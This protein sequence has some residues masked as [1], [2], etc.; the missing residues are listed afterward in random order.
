GKDKKLEAMQN[1]ADRTSDSLQKHLEEQICLLEITE[2]EH[3]VGDF[4]IYNIDDNGYLR[5]PL[6]E[7]FLRVCDIEPAVTVAKADSVLKRIQTC[8]PPGV[9][10]RDL[11][12]CLLIQLERERGWDLEKKIVR[13]HLDDVVAN[14]LPKIARATGES[15]EVIDDAIKMIKTLNPKPG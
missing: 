6:D 1:T 12:E 2:R 8:D 9:G 15:L 14:R 3:E 10:A 11:K 5:Y 4:L 7:E 13:D